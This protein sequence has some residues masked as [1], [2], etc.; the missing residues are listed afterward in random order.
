ME[1]ANFFT[2][3]D[4]K[5]QTKELQMIKTMLPFVEDSK[6]QQLHMLIMF[7]ELQQFTR[8]LSNSQNSLSA[9]EH[10][11]PGEIRMD[12]CEAL[13]PYCNERERETIDNLLNLFSVMES[14][15]AMFH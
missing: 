12:M 4:R 5:M 10:R 11:S 13:K 15:D 3:Y 14:Y 9:Q 1:A 7:L 6:K 8:E 2:E